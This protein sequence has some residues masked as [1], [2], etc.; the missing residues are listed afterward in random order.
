V[1]NIYEEHFKSSVLLISHN[2]IN[3]K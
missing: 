1:W 2:E 3:S